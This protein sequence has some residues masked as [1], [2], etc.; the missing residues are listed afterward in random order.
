MFLVFDNLCSN[1]IPSEIDPVNIINRIISN[2]S[3]ENRSIPPFSP[4]IL[5]L[6]VKLFPLKTAEIGEQSGQVYYWFCQKVSTLRHRFLTI[7]KI[8]LTVI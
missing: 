5:L 4:L 1:W 7:V 3:F 2:C 6:F 8:N